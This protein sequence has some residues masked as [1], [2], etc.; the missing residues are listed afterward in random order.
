MWQNENIAGPQGGIEGLSAALFT[1]V[2]GWSK[3]EL[4][5]F[6]AKVKAEHRSTKIHSY[7]EL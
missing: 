5:V 7:Y 2:L 1:R 3:L 4:D 6:M